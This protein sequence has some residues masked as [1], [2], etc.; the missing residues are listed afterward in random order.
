MVGGPRIFEAEE[1]HLITVYAGV[2]SEGCVHLVFFGHRDLMISR[3]N[4]HENEECMSGG[5]VN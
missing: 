4:I 1:H 5:R 3:I 2:G